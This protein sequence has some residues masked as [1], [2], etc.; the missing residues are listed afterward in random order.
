MKQTRARA[1]VALRVHIGARRTL[2]HRWLRP[3][4][5]AGGA[6]AKFAVAH[7]HMLRHAC[8]Y[9]L[10]N[11]GIDTRT[12]QGYLGHKSIQ[13]TVRYTE[14]APTRFPRHPRS[15]CHNPAVDD[16]L[17]RVAGS[18]APPA[19]GAFEQRANCIKPRE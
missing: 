1:E 18:A 9:K 16:G 7:P 10:A 6:E 2:Q 14:L 3:H 5:R 15:H 4:G 11:E 17:H 19:P 13:H 12:I 8:G